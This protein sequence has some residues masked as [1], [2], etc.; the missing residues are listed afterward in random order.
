VYFVVYPTAGVQ[1]GPTVTLEVY[2]DG[3][4]VGI[5]KLP[6]S[7]PKADGSIPMLLRINPDPGQCDMIVTAHQGTMTS[8]SSLSVKITPGETANPN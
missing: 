8:E 3:R 1:G 4:E 5:Q 6:A 2:R 7:Q